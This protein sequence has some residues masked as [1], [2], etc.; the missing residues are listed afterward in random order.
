MQKR[1]IKF[2]F[3]SAILFIISFS[4]TAQIYVSIR[5]TPPVVVRP[6]QPSRTHVWVNEEWEPN[7][8]SYKYSGGHWAPPPQP[9]YYRKPGHWKKSKRGQVWVKGSWGKHNKKH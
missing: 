7:G 4:A 3:L 8:T 6:P 2:S 9:G 1:S 5:P